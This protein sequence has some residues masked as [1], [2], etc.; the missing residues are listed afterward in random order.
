V[1]IR[2]ESLDPADN[3]VPEPLDDDESDFDGYGDDP[4]AAGPPHP[5]NWNLLTAEEAETEWLDLNRWVHWLRNT[6]GLP[7]SVVPPFWHHHSELVWEL[8]ALHLH[9]LCAYDPEQN[10]SAPLDWHREFA[11]ARERLR[12]WVAASGTRLNADRPTRQTAWPGEQAAPVVEDVAIESWEAEFVDF[13]LDDVTQR[14]SVEDA[15]YADLHA[16]SGEAS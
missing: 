14:Q 1:A 11:A 15:F 6:Y 10:G 2:A 9:W 8:S 16:S 7:V 12:D 4:Q 13:V 3:P 5:I